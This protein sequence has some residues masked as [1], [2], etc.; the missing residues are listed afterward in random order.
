MIRNLFRINLLKMAMLLILFVFSVIA[1]A[2]YLFYIPL[3]AVDEYDTMSFVDIGFSCYMYLVMWMM[4]AAWFHDSF[5]NF[6]GLKRKTVH[7]WLL[8]PVGVKSRRKNIYHIF[9]M[10][11]SYAFTL[12]GFAVAYMFT[13]HRDLKAFSIGGKLSIIDSLYFSVITAATVGYGDIVPVSKMA[14][15]IVMTQIVVCLAYVVFMFS[16]CSSYLRDVTSC[17]GRFTGEN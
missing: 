14:K 7:E 5:V 9:V 6:Y 4:I 1:S 11:L 8:K 16:I 17:N 13:S 2:F 12:W 15:I 10:I 3:V